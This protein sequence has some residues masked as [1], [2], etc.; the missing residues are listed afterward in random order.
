M[1]ALAWWWLATHHFGGA[2]DHGG[3]QDHDGGGRPAGTKAAVA[4]PSLVC[5]PAA[6][7]QAAG[8]SLSAVVMRPLRG[9]LTGP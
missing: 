8:I 2:G 6:A 3:G 7:Q 4:Q 1:G 5:L 9:H